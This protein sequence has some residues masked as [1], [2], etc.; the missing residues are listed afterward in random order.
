MSNSTSLIDQ[1]SSTQANKEVVANA[2]F[3]AAS[4]AMLWGR[5]ASTT[6]GL[7]WG[8]YGGWYGG[9][10]INDG[11]VTLTASATNYVY[12]SATSG[13]V[14]VNTTGFPAG[15]VTLYVIVAGATTV[16]SYTDQRSYQPYGTST[17]SSTLSGLSD[18][19]VTEGAGIDQNA[20]AWDNATGKWV[21]KSIS[22]APV[23]F[24]AYNTSAQSIPNAA[25][26]VITGWTSTK[27]TTSGAWNAGT[28]TFTAPTAGW[29][30]VS[31]QFIFATASWSASQ[32]LAAALFINGAEN[33]ATLQT[34]QG[35]ATQQF[36]TNDVSTNVYLNAGDTLQ[37]AAFQSTG[38][39]LALANNSNFNFASVVQ[40]T[41][42]GLAAQPVDL[43]SYQP[44]APSASAVVLSAITPQAVT[45]PAS[46][47]G[48]YAKAGTAATASTTFSIKKN[49]SS[50][51]S[52]NF[53]AGATSGTFTF[54][55]AV[56]T[57]PGDVVQVV[58]PASPDATLANINL[59]VVGTR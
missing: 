15:S 54:T 41:P 4:P 45:F 55:S 40:V 51:G 37:F 13:A 8:Y 2:N 38:S 22:T 59:A 3:D 14:S 9:A 16:T 58:A 7:T 18:V 28:G 29:Y 42:P 20:L 21:A 12:A 52:L 47:T 27:D 57:S 23:G 31:C 49:G 19:N 44:G 30:N 26:T 39:A 11:T 17:G 53:A 33:E 1:I 24:R 48:S 46:L 25:Y 6:S 32:Q 43:I 36:V 35:S 10:Q 5:R 50:I 56:T 34:L